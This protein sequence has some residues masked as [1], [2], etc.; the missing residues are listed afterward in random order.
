MWFV[1]VISLFAAHMFEN[2]T[3]PVGPHDKNK[4]YDADAPE[5]Y[6]NIE[7]PVL[8]PQEDPYGGDSCKCECHS[9]VDDAKLKGMN[10]HC[11]SCGTRVRIFVRFHRKQKMYP[12]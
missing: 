5:L 12:C 10:E 8:T 4:A 11:A 1:F 7:L 2:L 9:L 6:E 3:C